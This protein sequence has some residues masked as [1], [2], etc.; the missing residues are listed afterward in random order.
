M[1]TPIKVIGK[2]AFILCARMLDFNPESIA[3]KSRRVQ[4]EQLRKRRN[5][6]L[7]RHNNFWRLYLIKSWLIIEEPGGQVFTYYSYPNLPAPTPQEIVGYMRS[8]RGV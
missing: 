6:L 5:N 3:S 7:R 2:L 8:F 1:A 4:K